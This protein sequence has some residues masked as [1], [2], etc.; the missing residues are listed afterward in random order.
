MENSPDATII[1]HEPFLDNFEILKSRGEKITIFA[2]EDADAA[3]I[4]PK[5]NAFA[6]E[7]RKNNY[8]EKIVTAKEPLEIEISEKAELEKYTF[9]V[10][11]IDKRRFADNPGYS[12]PKIIIKE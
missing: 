12:A 10:F 7:L 4:I 6:A 1:S 5:I 8:E 9:H 3:V 11:V 2:A